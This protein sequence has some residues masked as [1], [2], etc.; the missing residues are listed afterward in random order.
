M[1]R[2]NGDLIYRRLSSDLI[3]SPFPVTPLKPTPINASHV[4]SISFSCLTS[5]QVTLHN[6]YLHAVRAGCDDVFVSGPQR[7]RELSLWP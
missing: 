6:G 2:P 5:G 4:G 7:G 3:T 1:V